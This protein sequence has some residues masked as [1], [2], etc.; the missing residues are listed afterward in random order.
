MWRSC[1]LLLVLGLFAG[2]PVLAQDKSNFLLGTAVPAAQGQRTVVVG[3]DTKWVNVDHDEVVRFSFGNSEFGW[4]FDGPGQRPID[5]QS[6]APQGA[7]A[8]PVTVYVK[9]RHSRP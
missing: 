7:L 2:L 9:R 5:L 6:I 1:G 4:K 3:A 8:A